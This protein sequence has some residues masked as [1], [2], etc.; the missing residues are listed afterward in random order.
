MTD[1]AER[2]KSIKR[3]DRVRLFAEREHIAKLER[4]RE[5]V[6]GSLDGLL[7]PLGVVS[8]VAAGRL[9]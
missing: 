4:V 7:F 5:L 3:E 6:F 2:D 9:P 1:P 8:G